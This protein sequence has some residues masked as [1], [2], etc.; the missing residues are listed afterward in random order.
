MYH[1]VRPGPADLPHLKYLLLDDFR[2]QLDHFAAVDRFIGLDE[3]LEVLASGA[4]PDDGVILTFD[5]AFSDHY[6]YVFP[7][8]IR[9]GLWGIFY[10]STGMYAT[11]K[12]MDVHRAHYL[13]GRHGGPEMMDALN[14]RLTPEMLSDED[15]QRFKSV[16][17]VR[18]DNEAAFTLFKKIVN[19]TLEPKWRA[20]VLDELMGEF[21]A[22]DRV[23]ESYYCRPEMLFEMQDQGMIVGSHSVSHAVLSRL[24]VAEQRREIIESF[25]FLEAVTGGL[26]LRTFCYP[27]GGWH[28]FTPD[29]ER[30]LAEAGCA[31]SFNVEPRD[32]TAADLAD[33]PQ[34]LPRFDCNQFPPLAAIPAAGRAGGRG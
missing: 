26:R 19:Y 33:H 6:R 15:W 17:Y 8:L 28:S 3:L 29:T 20:V 5:D 24:S 7:E 4:P 2:K 9:R 21:A 11:G 27:Y 13:L 25:V 30:L 12:L 18:Q 32:I 14:R 31:F 22:E 1:Y 34:A 10:V 23:F 16:V